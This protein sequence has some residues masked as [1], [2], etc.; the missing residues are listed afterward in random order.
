MNHSHHEIS[1]DRDDD[2]PHK[3]SKLSEDADN[4]SDTSEESEAALAVV[5]AAIGAGSQT[6]LQ[7]QLQVRYIEC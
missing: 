4:L 5:S 7:N 2:R 3:K 1:S 6:L